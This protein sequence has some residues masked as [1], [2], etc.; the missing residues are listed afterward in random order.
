MPE[1]HKHTSPLSS[2]SVFVGIEDLQA[3]YRRGRSTIYEL[4]RQAGFPGEVAPGRWRLDQVEAYELRVS[5]AGPAP[6]RRERKDTATEPAAAETIDVLGSG[7][8]SSK[9]T[10]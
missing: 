1:Q 6:K 9:E 3:R 2:A 8:S 10:C 5:Q 4:V 7:R